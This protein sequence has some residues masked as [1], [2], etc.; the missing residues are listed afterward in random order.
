M[1]ALV[2]STVTMTSPATPGAARWLLDAALNSPIYKAVLVP[3]AKDMMVETAEANGVPWRDALTWI[4]E[5]A[6]WS[7]NTDEQED[8][9]AVPEYYRQPFHAYEEGNLCW[10][11]A[12]GGAGGRSDIAR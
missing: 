4:Q 3:K 1:L 10:E 7:L 8:A 2:L 11:A 6:P 9:V 5:Q 12:W